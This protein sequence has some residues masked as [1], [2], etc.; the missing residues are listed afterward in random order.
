MT[1]FIRKVWFAP[2]AL[3][4]IGAYACSSESNAPPGSSSGTTP[5]GSDASSGGPG[6]A[7]SGPP[8]LDAAPG[9]PCPTLTAATQAVHVVMAVTWPGS[10][11]TNPGSGNVH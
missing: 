6:I 10:V 11:G 8:D 7:D 2:L 4:A 5:P 3:V 9:A 1:S